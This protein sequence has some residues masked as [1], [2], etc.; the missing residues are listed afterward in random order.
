L[1]GAADGLAVE[2]LA[3]G[4]SSFAAVAGWLLIANA[5]SEMQARTLRAAMIV[6]PVAFTAGGA[7]ASV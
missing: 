7:G 2:G 6:P 1:A 5:I 3:G 4:L